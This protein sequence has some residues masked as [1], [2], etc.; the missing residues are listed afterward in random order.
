MNQENKLKKEKRLKRIFDFDFCFSD[1]M[2]KDNINN[3]EYI[4]HRG[5]TV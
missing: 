1:E 2:F 3:C 5:K 4:T